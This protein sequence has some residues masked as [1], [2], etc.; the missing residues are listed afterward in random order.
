MVL[1]PDYG[2]HSDASGGPLSPG[3]V[4]VIVVDDSSGKPFKVKAPNGR[5]WWYVAAA[6]RAAGGGSAGC[7][8]A[9][10]RSHSGQSCLVCGE[11]WGEHRGHNCTK[12][13]FAGRR[14][15]F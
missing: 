11:G 2:S 3:E 14:G 15:A 12:S 1:S 8:S 10:S 4:G 9:C 13:G 5:E 7:D 6:L